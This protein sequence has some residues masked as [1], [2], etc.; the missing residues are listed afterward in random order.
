MNKQINSKTGKMRF[1][2][3]LWKFPRQVSSLDCITS[4]VTMKKMGHVKEK[5]GRKEEQEMKHSK[6]HNEAYSRKFHSIP[7]ASMST[8]KSVLV[9]MQAL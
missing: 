6:L 2:A 5:W 9:E 8:E 1:S 4:V 3:N 7:E